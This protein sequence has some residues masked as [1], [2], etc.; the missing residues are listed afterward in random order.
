MAVD[1]A[2]ENTAVSHSLQLQ[3]L[4]FRILAMSNRLN[5]PKS[6]NLFLFVVATSLL[7]IFVG[8]I[9]LADSNMYVLSYPTY[10]PTLNKV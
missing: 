5:K 2:K 10:L 9:K 8:S 4:T 7:V 6:T 3:L 1:Y